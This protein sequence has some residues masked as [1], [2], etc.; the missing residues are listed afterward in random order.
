MG[1]VAYNRDERI[2][3]VVIDAVVAFDDDEGVSASTI[4][5]HI[6]RSHSA[7]VLGEF[8]RPRVLHAIDRLVE[9]GALGENPQDGAP[10]F[11]M[12][13]DPAKVLEVARG[14]AIFA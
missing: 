4:Q 3:N 7:F 10:S 12:L 1:Q 13:G 11:Y 9:Y 14:R 8:T 5:R 6:E 2:R